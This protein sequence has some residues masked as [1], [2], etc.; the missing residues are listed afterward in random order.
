M[1]ETEV[2]I[3]HELACAIDSRRVSLGLDWQEVPTEQERGLEVQAMRQNPSLTVKWLKMS[4]GVQIWV[5]ARIFPVQVLM[6]RKFRRSVYE[7]LQGLSHPGANATVKLMTQRAVWPNCKM[8][9]CRW[10][11]ECLRCQRAKVARH[12]K[13]RCT[14]S[15]QQR[16]DFSICIWTL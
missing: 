13:P 11:R 12:T 2:A 8:Q 16:R 1:C 7:A 9:I 4:M 14:I 15:K 5:D 3:E 6:P 10:A